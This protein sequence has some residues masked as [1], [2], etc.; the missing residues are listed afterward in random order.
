V[1]ITP[2]LT[3]WIGMGGGMGWD[4][5]L[6]TLAE[7]VV[8]QGLL[9]LLLMLVRSDRHPNLDALR[10]SP[11]SAAEPASTETPV[12]VDPSGRMFIFM[13]PC[14]NEERVVKA[15]L[16]RLLGLPYR[17]F[18]VLVIDDA[19]DDATAAIVGAVDDERVH[20]VRRE[21]PAA[22]EGKGEA[23]NA[24]IRHILRSGLLQDKDPADVIVCVL[25]A[26]GRLEPEAPEAVAP[27]FDDPTVAGVQIGVRINNRFTN[28][29]AR[30]QDVE[31]VV[32]TELFQ[33]GRRHFGSV[34]LGGNGQFMRLIALLEFGDA[35]WS[36]SLTEDLDLGVRLLTH[37]WRNDVCPSVFVHQQGVEDLPRLIRQRTRWFQGHLQSWTLIPR[38][39]RGVPHRARPDLLY[40]LTSPFLLL[41]ASL[42]TLSLIFAVA[43]VAVAGLRGYSPGLSWMAMAYLLVGAPAAVVGTVYRDVERDTRISL[44][45][46]ILLGHVYVVYGLI[47]YVSGWWAVWRVIRRQ[48]GWSKTARNIEPVAGSPV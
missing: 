5:V 24:G 37:G 14:L 13:L 33:R 43:A 45:Q 12:S 29:L 3:L 31:F 20:L 35:P 9:Y 22:R 32:Y 6:L 11:Q 7:L 4:K 38:V 18:A 1:D 26:D 34:G 19:S 23:L 44:W 30:M 16:D 40:H 28:L 15:S 17:D 10:H 2:P 39:L 36:R 25:D 27:M 46:G 42:L 41:I 21:A 47:W 48:R 8:V